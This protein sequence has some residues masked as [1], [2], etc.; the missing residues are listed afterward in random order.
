M[1]HK[2]AIILIL[3]FPHIV[4]LILKEKEKSSVAHR[5]QM[6]ELKGSLVSHISMQALRSLQRRPNTRHWLWMVPSLSSGPQ[7]I[8]MH[9]H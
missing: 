2:E 7:H 1:G 8:W 3:I 5:T 9:L 6:S 4:I